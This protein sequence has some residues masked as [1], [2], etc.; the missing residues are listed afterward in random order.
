MLG[1]RRKLGSAGRLSKLERVVPYRGRTTTSRTPTSV[2]DPNLPTFRCAFLMATQTLERTTEVGQLAAGLAHEIRNPLHAIQLNLHTL[3]R[4]YDRGQALTGE[5]IR[6]M[7]EQ[8]SSEIDRIE[9]LMQQ[10]LGFATPDEPRDEVVEVVSEIRAI[11]DFL[12]REM[13]RSNV[14]LQLQLPD[15]PIHVRMD[16]GRLRQVVL[17]LLQNAQQSME[18]GGRIIVTA[19][20]EPEMALLIISDSGP[21]IPEADR[22]RIF[23]PFYST[24]RN[25]TGLGLSIVRRF[26]Q[27]VHG[28]VRCETNPQG[29]ATFRISLPAVNSPETEVRPS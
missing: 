15:E 20:R 25:G 23:E 14:E 26:V 22:Q 7:L 1:N 18:G 8:S 13:V 24:R 28:E 21:G 10:L 3:Q 2:A 16:H 11:A 27:E 19:E 9:H 12:D 4:A 6:T 17:N 5:D 29:G